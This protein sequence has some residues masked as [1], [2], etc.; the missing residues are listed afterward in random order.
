M[1]LMSC[2]KN[3]IPNKLSNQGIILKDQKA[4]SNVS[5]P[6]LL[7]KRIYPHRVLGMGLAALPITLILNH[8]NAPIYSWIWCAFGCFI[9][10][11]L[12]YFIAKKSK[13][14]YTIER[15]NLTFDSFFAGSWAPLLHFNLLPSVMLIAI[16]MADKIS[17]GVRKMWLY[18]AIFVVLGI[19]FTGS[20]TGFQVNLESNIQVILATLPVIIVHS[21]VVSI[22]SYKL[23]R[24]VH[25][26]NQNLREL[27][28]RDPLTNIYNCRV[29]QEQA[30][31]LFDKHIDKKIPLS[32]LIIDIDNFKQVNDQYGHATGD[33]LILAITKI[34][35]K[36]TSTTSI[37]GRLGGDEFGL[38]LQGD[39]ERAVNIG[40]KILSDV[41]KII[42]T[43]ANKQEFSVS[44][45]TAC[46]SLAFDKY[47]D[48]F[49]SADKALYAAK[50]S[51]RN[52][53]VNYGETSKCR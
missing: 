36:H 19:L 4:I 6:E 2:L 52:T 12:A 29:W 26:K 24:R 15:N 1:G 11:H 33:K 42:I 27:N 23:V 41:R 5:Q 51:G 7:H 9:W 3:Q 10:P 44:I 45:G 49:N 43:E 16:T 18:G 34:I 14:P 22:S 53:L 47:Q 21:L 32:M 40:Y 28:R 37:S 25:V 38:V 8:I 39:A 17:S 50:N 46:S 30:Y 31:E 20:F 13:N 48:W 35:R